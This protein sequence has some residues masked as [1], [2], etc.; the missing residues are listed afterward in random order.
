MR[1]KQKEAE[2]N[3]L[4]QKI[5]EFQTAEKEKLSSLSSDAQVC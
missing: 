3:E 2:T 5:R 1:R 4:E